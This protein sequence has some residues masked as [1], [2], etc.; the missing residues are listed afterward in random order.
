MNVSCFSLVLKWNIHSKNTSLPSNP[1]NTPCLHCI[2]VHPKDL[3]HLVSN[4][5]YGCWNHGMEH[6]PHYMCFM[7]GINRSPVNP[8]NKR[9]P[10]N[11][12]VCNLW[13]AQDNYR[14]D[15]K[16]PTLHSF[17]S[18]IK[19]IIFSDFVKTLFPGIN[20]IL[21]IYKNALLN[22][23]LITINPIVSIRQRWVYFQQ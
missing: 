13:Y 18:H 1:Q 4:R 7:W 8:F 19:A 23:M 17:S 11:K 20:K 3:K 22:R 5:H 9:P 21:L 10:M 2:M 6:F 12:T 14:L 16:A 15:T